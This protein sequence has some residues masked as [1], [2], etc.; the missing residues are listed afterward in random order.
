MSH[1]QIIWRLLIASAALL[2]CSAAA[3]HNSLALE[4]ER[5]AEQSLSLAPGS[6]RAQSIDRQVPLGNCASGWEWSFPYEARTTVQVSCTASP[7]VRRYVSMKYD[8]AASGNTGSS[9]PE[10]STRY[11]VTAARDLAV[12]HVLS[13]T[14]L[15]V[16]T[17]LPKGRSLQST[18]ADP[19]SLVGLSLTRA[20]REGEPLGR[21]DAR[22]HLVVRRKSPVTGWYSFPGGRVHAKL[23]AM[24]NGKAGDWIDLENP[25]SG[26]RVRGRVH[27]N[28]TVQISRPGGPL[29][30][31][32]VGT[33]NPSLPVD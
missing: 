18:L 32:V 3:E 9:G 14:D 8:T 5:F 21:A 26:R 24:E 17:E 15:E 4:A 25:Q 30:S 11:F 10:G 13:A 31:S 33:E 16:A 7:S 2:P 29:S 20:V 6:A 1:N 23:V 27:S 28:G 12:G 22:A 19:D